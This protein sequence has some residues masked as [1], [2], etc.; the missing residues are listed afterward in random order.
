MAPQS[1]EMAPGWRLP[2][3]G[4]RPVYRIS[5]TFAVLLESLPTLRSH[6]FAVIRKR[7]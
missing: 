5:W 4:W 6:G 3:C 1:R 2:W 7:A